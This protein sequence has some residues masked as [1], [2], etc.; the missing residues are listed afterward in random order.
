M[1]LIDCYPYKNIALWVNIEV[2]LLVYRPSPGPTGEF[3]LKFRS[4]R[5]KYFRDKQQRML[6]PKKILNLGKVESVSKVTK[7]WGFFINVVEF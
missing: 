2:L 6:S 3:L 1:Q 4:A 5:G 7:L